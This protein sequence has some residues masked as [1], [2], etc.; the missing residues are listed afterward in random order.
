MFTSLQW[1]HRWE[2]QCPV[3]PCVASG[4]QSFLDETDRDA[5][6]RALSMRKTHKP[7]S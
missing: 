3:V 7:E 1:N 2:K 4:N 5:T 6:K